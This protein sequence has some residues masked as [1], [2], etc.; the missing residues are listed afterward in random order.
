MPRTEGNGRHLE[1]EWEVPVEQVGL[2]VVDGWNL[3]YLSDTQAR[4]EQVIK[5]KLAPLIAACRQGGLTVIH[6]P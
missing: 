6:A 2:V 5:V 3:H 4:N 1:L